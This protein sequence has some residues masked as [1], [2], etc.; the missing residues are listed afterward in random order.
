VPQSGDGNKGLALRVRVICWDAVGVRHLA[1]H[2]V[3][4]ARDPRK[5]LVSQ[6]IASGVS[7]A[8]MAVRATAVWRLKLN[9]YLGRL[10]VIGSRFQDDASRAPW[11]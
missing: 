3:F 11:D 4:V 10:P 2:P 8:P 5:L 7:L 6:P 1:D 9:R